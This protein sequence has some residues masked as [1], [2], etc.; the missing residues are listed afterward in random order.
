MSFL[1]AFQNIQKDV[2]NW[3]R[4][5]KNIQGLQAILD[6]RAK[7]DTIREADIQAGSGKLRTLKINYYPPVCSDDGTG[8]EN[9][10]DAGTVLEPAQD[11]FTLSNV[12]SSEVY[13]INASD[14]RY[15]DGNYTFNDNAR[16]QVKSVLP[17]VRQKLNLAVTTS[18]VGH[19]GLLPD[20]TSTLL[21][22]FV[23]PENA[24]I[25]TL[26]LNTI[27]R[28]YMDSGYS[29]PMV[30]GGQAVY[31]WMASRRIAAP[32][33]TTGQD[34]NKLPYGDNL[35][36]VPEVPVV[37]ADD[38]N[39]HII[40]FDPQM[41]KFVSFTENAGIFATDIDGLDLDRIFQRGGTDYIKG[42]LVDPRTGLIWDLNV[43]YDKCADGGNGAWKFQFKIHWDIFYMPQQVC[44]IQGV[45]SIFHFKTCLPAAV[46]CPDPAVTS[47]VSAHTFGF[48]TAGNISYPY[49]IQKITVGGNTSEYDGVNS[50][51]NITALKNM[52]NDVAAGMVTFTVSGTR[53]QYSGYV[54]LTV[55]INDTL[56]WTFTP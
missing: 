15:E 48:D 51:A 55:T 18:L 6:A 36:Y 31:N 24:S 10:C 46:D 22:P 53:L 33:T 21:L 32:D 20:G 3:T 35:Y 47:T 38:T 23:S 54:G 14:I 34:M 43:D 56:T 5:S 49:A 2:L 17:T 50:V 9:I 13:Q 30:L 26:G 25:N 41:L 7:N 40:T 11:F 45:N 4:D 12:T 52:L 29:D 44:N 1:N 39:D 42:V 28:T 37:I 8:N 27:D 19:I 16:Y